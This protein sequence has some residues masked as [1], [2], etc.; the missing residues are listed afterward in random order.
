MGFVGEATVLGGPVR[1]ALGQLVVDPGDFLLG[2]GQRAG[3]G[4]K[5]PAQNLGPLDR[6]TGVGQLP[7]LLLRASRGRSVDLRLTAVVAAD[8]R[9]IAPRG[10]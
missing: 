9:L 6:A 8:S 3:H 7:G 4:E 10:G 1:V 2:S 5:L